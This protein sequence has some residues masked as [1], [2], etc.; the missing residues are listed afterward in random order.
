MVFVESVRDSYFDL[1]DV[2]QPRAEC[3]FRRWMQSYEPLFKRLDLHALTENENTDIQ[4]ARQLLLEGENPGLF[5]KELEPEFLRFLRKTAP[6]LPTDIFTDI[7]NA[8]RSNL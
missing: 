5:D 7:V 8:N 6:R 2:D 4:F 3:I 1:I